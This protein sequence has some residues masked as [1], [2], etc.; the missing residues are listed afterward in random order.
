MEGYKE[1]NYNSGKSFL[2]VRQN[3]FVKSFM[4]SKLAPELNLRNKNN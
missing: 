1:L 4:F 2:K 3:Y